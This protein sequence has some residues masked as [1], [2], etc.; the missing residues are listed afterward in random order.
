MV[1]IPKS[2]LELKIPAS[3][4]VLAATRA[5]ECTGVGDYQ[6]VCLWAVLSAGLN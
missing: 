2:F 1:T 4:K 6:D 3:F 5:V